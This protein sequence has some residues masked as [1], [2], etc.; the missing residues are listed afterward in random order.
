MADDFPIDME[1][2]LRIAVGSHIFHLRKANDEAKVF[3]AAAVLSA[4]S[5]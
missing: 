5:D 4:R 1:C 2:W 3:A